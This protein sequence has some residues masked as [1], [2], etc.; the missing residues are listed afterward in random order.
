M[1]FYLGIILLPLFVI[2]AL[3][4]M[5]FGRR[6]DAVKNIP[7]AVATQ[8]RRTPERAEGREP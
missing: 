3:L 5:F 8:T 2:L 7:N 1:I 4:Y 6:K